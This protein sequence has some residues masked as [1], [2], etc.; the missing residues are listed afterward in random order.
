MSKPFVFKLNRAGVRALMRSDEMRAIC[1]EKAEACR[2][3]CGEGYE[4]DTFTGK[5]RVNAMVWA[6]TYQAKKDNSD[7]NTLLRCLK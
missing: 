1:E 5:N 2:A 7:N 4:A 6:D 3:R